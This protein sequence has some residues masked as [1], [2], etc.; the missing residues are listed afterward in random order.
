MTKALPL[1][2]GMAESD[3]GEDMENFDQPVVAVLSEVIIFIILTSLPITKSFG[4]NQG[5]CKKI[6]TLSESTFFF[7]QRSYP[8]LLPT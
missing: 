6:T 1:G 3:P 7:Q 5:S 8:N 2:S 4:K